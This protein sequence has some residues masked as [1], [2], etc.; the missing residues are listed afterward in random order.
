M[1]FHNL[2]II[3]NSY[4]TYHKIEKANLTLSFRKK[5]LEQ[6]AFELCGEY[7]EEIINNIKEAHIKINDNNENQ[8]FKKCK[9]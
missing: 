4:N 6:I 7:K 8:E 1:H 9:K 2:S 5:L 3:Y